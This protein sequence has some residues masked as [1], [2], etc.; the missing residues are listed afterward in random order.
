MF[1]SVSASADKSDNWNGNEP[2]IG[3]WIDWYS[4]GI[5]IEE[6]QS[7]AYYHYQHD[8]HLSLEYYGRHRCEVTIISW[9]GESMPPIYSFA[10]TAV[11][12]IVDF[13]ANSYSAKMLQYRLYIPPYPVSF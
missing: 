5:D 9:I 10:T 3:Y 4:D 7:G 8:H 12:Q 13:S 2:I 6:S 11:N 1:T